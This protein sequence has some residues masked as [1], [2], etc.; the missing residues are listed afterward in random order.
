MLKRNHLFLCGSAAL[1]IG[2]ETST[3]LA[4]Q[5]SAIEEVVVTARRREENLQAVPISITALSAET[6]RANNILTVSDLQYFVPSMNLS[7]AQSR[8]QVTISIRGQGGRNPGSGP[9]VATYFNEVPLTGGTNGNTNSSGGGP[10]RYYDLENVQVLKGPQGTLFGRNTTGGAVL[11]QTRRPSD[12]FGG[13]V[14][15]ALGNYTNRE[16]RFALNVPLIDGKILVRVAANA[17][18]REGFTQ[19]LG[20]PGYPGG[21][22]LDNRN[23]FAH[24]LS[25]T[26]KPSDNF[27]NH[28]IYDAI[29]S[30][31]HGTSVILRLAP[32]TGTATRFFPG[33]QQ[34]LAQQQALGVRTQVPIDTG[35]FSSYNHYSFADIAELDLAPDL[36]LRNIF[37]Y[38][39]VRD[40]NTFDGDGTALP[41]IASP[42]RQPGANVTVQYSEEVQLQGRALA[43][44]L[45]WVA[46]G[47]YLRSPPQGVNDI[48]S[49]TLGSVARRQTR[50]GE[51]SRALYAQGTYDLGAV[52]E[53]L[54]FTGGLR[55]TWDK[56]FSQ[57]Q[58]QFAATCTVPGANAQCQ[59]V[60]RA[61]FRAPTWTL[62]L[63]YQAAPG[64][65]LYAAARR[66]YRTGGF[67]ITAQTQ[68]NRSFKPEYVLET[69]LGVKSDWQMGDAPVRANLALFHQDFTQ[70]QLTQAVVDN[71]VATQFTR[72][73][74]DA[75]LVGAEFEGEI[76]PT[77]NLHFGANL[78]WLNFKYT[79]LETGVN[80]LATRLQILV[81]RP[82]WKYGVNAR[83]RLPVDQ[84]A[85]SVELSAAWNW[86]GQAGDRQDVL[87]VNRAYGLLTLGASWN[88]IAGAPID[89][90]VFMTNATNKT[91][92]IGG[93]PISYLLGTS[94]LSY[95][96]PRMYGVRLRYRFGN[97]S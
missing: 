24:R 97:E 80:V 16:G 50:T 36:T 30:K 67:N 14:E 2:L 91:Y 92:T 5:S 83:Y 89:A 53:G 70:I 85:G 84:V 32:A 13:Y 69:E 52:V 9:A 22:D 17:Q 42:G 15:G 31:T 90:F 61:D 34:A 55:Y 77:E 59:L 88:S 47:F 27:R 43:G 76:S 60:G 86:T 8:D 19:S 12:A 48:F 45:A 1:L 33:I 26:L 87:G 21:V 57:T 94:A 18:K 63:D 20:M 72:N 44:R 95:G 62:G 3:A 35:Q 41:V 46:G 11:I 65:M 68:D 7:T 29:N 23:F 73:P 58:T 81:N 56:R 37:G 51:T 71:G 6:L 78:S 93:Y 66:G 75:R 40:A 25:V 74:G 39:H 54:K 49:P 82:R 96:E 38:G 28:F 4:Q 64:I 10:G 79:R